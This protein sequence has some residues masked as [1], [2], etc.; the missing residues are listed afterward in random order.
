MLE[1]RYQDSAGRVDSTT[2]AFGN[3]WGMSRHIAAPGKSVWAT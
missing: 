2:S 1:L 3:A